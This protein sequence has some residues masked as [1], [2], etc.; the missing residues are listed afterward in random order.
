[1]Y[2]GNKGLPIVARRNNSAFTINNF[3]FFSSLARSF[4]SLAISAFPFGTGL[5]N[6]EAGKRDSSTQN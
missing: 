1:M 5:A 4:V 3:T 6:L 2:R